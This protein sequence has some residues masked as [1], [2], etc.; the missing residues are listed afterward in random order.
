MSDDLGIIYLSNKK[1][2]ILSY[3]YHLVGYN[4][5]YY[6]ILSPEQIDNDD[7]YDWIY[8]YVKWNANV[9]QSRKGL[10]LF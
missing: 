1:I 6:L 10:V 7:Y 8:P 3:T 9:S 5:F 2:L 4:K